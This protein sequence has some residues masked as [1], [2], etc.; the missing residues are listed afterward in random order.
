MPFVAAL[1][2]FLVIVFVARAS[3]VGGRGALLARGLPAR[4]LI[5]SAARTA[6]DASYGGQR[7]EVRSLVLDIEVPG[8]P[9]YEV[10]LSTMIPRI[11]EALPGATLDLRVD[12]AKPDNLAVVGPAG[13]SQWLGA[14]VGIPGQTW[15]VKPGASQ[16]GCGTVILVLIGLSL[17]FGAVLSFV[18][19]SSEEPAPAPSPTHTPRLA[20]TSPASAKAPLASPASAAST[21]VRH[22]GECEAVVRCCETIGLASC[23]G[24]SSETDAMC[25]SQLAQLRKAALKMGKHCP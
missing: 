11:C 16:A 5:L 12:P 10:S 2:V 24:F 9:P 15:A 19:G 14:A 23:Q 8:R 4:G 6:T 7:F 3:Q 20:P 22:H 21:S 13:S 1:V 17:G 25:A 18:G